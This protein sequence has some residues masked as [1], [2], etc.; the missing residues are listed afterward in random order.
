MGVPWNGLPDEGLACENDGMTASTFASSGP[1]KNLRNQL[2]KLR[3]LAQP[4]FLPLDQASGWQFIWLLV[5]LL[6]CVGGLVLA[7]LTALIRSLDRF[8]P[9][10][11]DKYLS[12]VSGT[13]ATIWSSWWGAAFVTLFLVGLASFV[14]FR[15]QLRQRRWLNWG[16][17]ATIVFM[18]LAVNGINT[19]IGFIYRDITNALVDKDQGG[20]YG[21][22]AIYGACFVIA[23]PIRVTQVYITAKLGIIWRE[24]LSKSLIGDYMKNKAYYVLNPNSEDET[25]V[26]NPDQRITQDTESFTAQSLSLA[27]GLF[28]A[29]LTFS[30]NILVLWS[31]SSRLTFALF[32]YSAVATTL[33]IVSGRNLVRIN[34][35]QLRYEADFRY[36]LVHIRDNAESIAFYSGE[37]QEKQESYRRLGSVVK[38]FN[39]LII[40]QVIIDVMRRS[41]SYAGVFLPFLVMA[42]V[43]FAG[44]IDFG[45]FNQANFAFNM[46]EGSLFFIVARIEQLARFAAGI[47]R[48]EGFQTKIEQVSKQAPSSNSRVVPGSN[49]IVIRSADL[50]PP[51][52]KNPVIE[53]L[54]IDIGDHEKLL[55]VGP[56]GCGKT[57][58][59]RMISGLWEP[60]RGSV[61]RPSMGDLLFIPQKPYML[62][63]S[64]REQLCYPADENRFS[65]E[66]LRSVLEQVSLQKLVTRYPDLDIKQDWPRI[67]SL[68]E[69]Q[70]L[71]FGR[72]LLNSPSF[73]VLDE[74]TSALDVKTE[75]QL[76]ELLVDRDLS[77]IS[78]GHRPSLKHFH[79]NVLELRGDGDWSLIPASSYQP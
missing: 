30:L 16:L 38:N 36:G 76:Y 58:L 25:D 20:F 69:Q 9:D 63:G 37:G 57:S 21:R 65:D 79:D 17:L 31:I 39:L 27:L 73:V 34:Y 28:D 68:G 50:Y 45:V 40:W 64:L 18:L 1:F 33:L 41:V 74:A 10:L 29:L 23:L 56:S 66:Q 15:Q 78:V 60:T 43:Y 19:G 62:L 14:A 35:D 2:A 3:H 71:A 51:N 4:F 7:V 46:V 59:L 24:W 53:D 11:T 61:E 55:V 13:I 75:K 8:Q 6:F 32:G 48:L 26:D 72:L 49:S 5:C 70:R 42:P 44:E 22:L 54:T 12:G 52:G 67:L 77:F 47:S